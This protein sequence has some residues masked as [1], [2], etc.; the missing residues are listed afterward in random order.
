ME[1]GAA[2]W[3]CR[4]VKFLVSLA[5]WG[6][7]PLLPLSSATLNGYQHPE[8]LLQQRMT[9][10][11]RQR[12]VN[13]HEQSRAPGKERL[14]EAS[15]QPVPWCARPLTLVKGSLCCSMVH[16]LHLPVCC[17]FMG[18]IEAHSYSLTIMDGTLF[19]LR[20]GSECGQVG[21]GCICRRNE[22]VINSICH[23][24]MR[25]ILINLKSLI[26]NYEQK[27]KN[28]KLPK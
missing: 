4:A 1:L 6:S 3:L 24:P 17:Q 14:M 23:S 12:A 15:T 28:F 19:G 16:A 8:D 21:R 7:F 13:K 9:I 27:V 10:W 22:I 2:R 18:P 11:L 5:S 25:L 20:E 26:Y